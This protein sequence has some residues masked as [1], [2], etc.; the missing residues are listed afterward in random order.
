MVRILSSPDSLFCGARDLKFSRSLY[1]ALQTFDQW[2]ARNTQ[3][4]PPG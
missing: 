4:I 3:R 2:L 1:P